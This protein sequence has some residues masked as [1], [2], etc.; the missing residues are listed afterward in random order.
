LVA[1]MKTEVTLSKKATES[2]E[3]EE[4]MNFCDV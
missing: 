3:K 1:D 4:S 2:E